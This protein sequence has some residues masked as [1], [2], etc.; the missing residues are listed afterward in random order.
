V[1]IR[2]VYELN[3]L[4]EQCR[5]IMLNLRLN[6]VADKTTHIDYA[7]SFSWSLENTVRPLTK[8]NTT[9]IYRLP[10]GTT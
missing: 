10:A 2:R 5:V 3:Y 4:S 8:L 9:V 1:W 7:L 6:A